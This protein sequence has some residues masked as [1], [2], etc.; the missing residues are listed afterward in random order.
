MKMARNGRKFRLALMSMF[1]MTAAFAVTATVPGMGVLFAE[2]M[3]GIATI[4][5]I[6][7]GGNVGAAY[8]SKKKEQPE[9][10]DPA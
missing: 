6:Y 3:T 10:D 9:G 8:F 5:A 2:H 1:I 7:C 4:Y